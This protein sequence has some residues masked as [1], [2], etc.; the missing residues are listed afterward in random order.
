[1]RIS[2]AVSVCFNHFVGCFLTIKSESPNSDT[3]GGR[4]LRSTMR[5]EQAYV[6]NGPNKICWA[7]HYH[8][9]SWMPFGDHLT[10][11]RKDPERK[12]LFESFQFDMA[13][14]FQLSI[15]L[16]MILDLAF[17]PISSSGSSNAPLIFIKYE[18]NII[19]RLI[20]GHQNHQ[21]SSRI[22]QIIK[23]H[24]NIINYHQWCP[25]I[26]PFFWVP[27]CRNSTARGC[28]AAVFPTWRHQTTSPDMALG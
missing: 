27:L 2:D 12:W 10:S 11:Y 16:N 17:Q 3:F 5:V 23:H 15:C 18:L 26:S 1:M 7:R 24:P 13:V 8:C 4:D 20:E 28:W 14:V 9:N 25:D 21:Q 19:S 22:V 6:K